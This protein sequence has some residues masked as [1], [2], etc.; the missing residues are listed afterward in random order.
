MKIQP[1]H[2]LRTFSTHLLYSFHRNRQKMS[3][4]KSLF[5]TTSKR[6]INSLLSQQHQQPSGKQYD[7]MMPQSKHLKK[8]NLYNWKPNLSLSDDVNYMDIVLLITRNSLLRQGSM[9][10]VIINPHLSIASA[11]SSSSSG[12]PK[13]SQEEKDIENTKEEEQKIMKLF[14]R[15]ENNIIAA[16]TNE[17]F[18]NENDSDIHAEIVAL[19][20]CNQSLNTSTTN[21]TAYITM[22]PCKKCFGALVKAGIKR[23]VTR[24][25]YPPIIVNVAKRE[26][27]ELCD[28]NSTVVGGDFMKNQQLRIQK[29]V[30]TYNRSKSIESS[31][32]SDGVL[33]DVKLARQKRKEDKAARK[34][35]KIESIKKGM[36]ETT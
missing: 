24:L 26:G 28:L 7:E 15:L 8:F 18:Y 21:C 31:T 19:G 30:D 16:S 12:T 2:R 25:E 33:D 17:S 9:G 20:E 34:R 35:M 29:I 1:S 4:E 32:C 3:A 14:R 36:V 6:P 23:I 27:I 22:S 10:C 5:S 13:N 11:P